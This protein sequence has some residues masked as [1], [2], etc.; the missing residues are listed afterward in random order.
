VQGFKTKVL[1]ES[2]NIEN[3]GTYYIKFLNPQFIQQ[4]IWVPFYKDK[5]QVTQIRN[6]VSRRQEMG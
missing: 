5:M 4:S 3:F 1:R 2:L 6:W